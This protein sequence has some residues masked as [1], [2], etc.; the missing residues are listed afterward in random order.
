VPLIDTHAHILPPDYRAELERRGLMAFPLPP[1]SGEMLDDLMARH[2][3]DAAVIGLSPPGVFFGDQGLADELARLV[4]ERTA[5]HVRAAPER[6]AGLA[7]LPLP[8]VDRALAEL[9]HALDTLGLEGVTL[10]SNVAGTYLGDPAWDPLFDELDRRG[11]YVFL[12]PTAGGPPALPEHPIWLYEFPFD[13]TR[14][15]AN[16]IY[17]GT[18]E[19]CPNVRLQVSHLGGTAPFLAHRLASLAAREPERATRAPAG[20][21]GYLQRLWY[22]TGLSNHALAVRPTI[23]LAGAERIVFGT[24]WPYADLPDAGDPAPDLDGLG[25]QART[26]IDGANAAALVPRL[27]AG[28]G[29]AAA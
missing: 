18:L 11:A 23:E 2:A 27:A 14:A 19:R 20:A 25:A 5:E 17:S 16:L 28:L 13:T 1:W 7:F 4:N 29:V 12:H 9:D 10:L 22:D 21:L 6:F 3:I 8:D 26:A 24:D 15:V